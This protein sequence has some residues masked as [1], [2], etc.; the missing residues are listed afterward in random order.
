VQR[1]FKK[2]LSF[3][4]ISIFSV[5]THATVASHDLTNR[6]HYYPQG[7]HLYDAYPWAL[8]YYYG[9]TLHD[10]L[11]R[12][13]GQGDIHRWPEHLQSFEVA[14]TFSEQNGLRRLVSPLVGVVAIAGDFAIRSGSNEPTIYEFD[15]YLQFRWANFPWNQYVVTSLAVGEG[16]SYVTSVPAIERRYSNNTKRLLN[17]LMLEATFAFPSYPRLQLVARIHHR[18]GAYG[19]YRAGNSGSNVI[20]L[21]LRYLID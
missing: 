5:Q 21:G 4:F 9:I 16:I 12:I 14:H 11:A 10:A 8:T 18:S 13:I 15:P 1:H 20:G 2:V 6:A 3:C 7:Q 17:F 19:L